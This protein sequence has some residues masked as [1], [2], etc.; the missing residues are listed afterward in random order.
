MKRRFVFIFLMMICAVSGCS[1]IPLTTMYKMMSVNPL[2]LE[3]SEIVVAVQAPNGI[4]VSNNDVVIKFEFTTND[5]NYNFEDEY[6][7]KLNTQYVLP[8]E[9][10]QE[11]NR[12]SKFYILQLSQNDTLKMLRGQ[13]LVKKYR[14]NN[15]DGGGSFNLSVESVCKNSQ[16]SV[17][18]NELNVFL[19][20]NENDEFFT[21]MEDLN[22]LE[23]GE[24]K[25]GY[26][27]PIRSCT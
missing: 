4:V 9:L 11:I 16:F 20:L 22:V 14:M 1:S 7:V 17:K 27:K 8:N 6:F 12:D 25:S 15:S 23:I 13:E 24:D 2:E 18:N 21:F 26:I 10:T 19:K 3:P 5:P